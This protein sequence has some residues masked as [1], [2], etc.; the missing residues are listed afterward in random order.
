MNDP[1]YQKIDKQALYNALISNQLPDDVM[2]AFLENE[3]NKVDQSKNKNNESDFSSLFKIYQELF[4]KI[5]KDKN[6]KFANDILSKFHDTE[7]DNKQCIYC[8]ECYE[9]SNKEMPLIRKNIVLTSYPPEYVYICPECGHEFHSEI[10]YDNAIEEGP[11]NSIMPSSDMR[12][13][14]KNEDIDIPYNTV[15]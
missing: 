6:E 13:I 14:T 1:K 8:K 9:R 5:V 4:N 15:M 12:I 11:I 3:A 10:L 7:N 2:I